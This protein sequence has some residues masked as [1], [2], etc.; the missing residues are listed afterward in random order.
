MLL[1]SLR[2]GFRRLLQKDS[3]ERDLS[4][5]VTHY[6]EM[7]TAEH[8]RRGLSR[9]D[10]ERAARVEFGGVEA[11]KERV[12]HHGWDAAVETVW[13]DVRYGWR[14][15]RRNPLFTLTTAITLAL[16]IGANT[17]M[18]SV[19]NGVM[20]RP[21]PYHDSSRLL[22]L[23]TD[24]IKRSL[25]YEN[26]AYATI[27]DWQRET[28]AFDD[29]AFFSTNR[30]T[31]GTGDSRERTLGAYASANLFPLLGI[32]PIKGRWLSDDDGRGQTP[33]AVISY[34]LWQRRFAADPDII[35]KPLV[36]DAS[37]GKAGP[38]SLTI[39]G[40]MPPGFY[41]PNR[42]TDIWVPATAYWR[43]TRESVERFPSWARRWTG[44]GRVKTGVSVA[45]ARAD[46]ARVG[47]HLAAVHPTSD[48]DFPGFA[49]NAVPILEY[50]TG[51]RL[52]LAL[53]LLMGAVALVL[54]VACANVGNLLLARGASR[55]HEVAVRRALGA[56][57]L[58]LVRQFLVESVLLAL[59]G[60]A[61]GVLVAAGATRALAVS[62]ADRLPRVNEISI[63]VNVLLFAA[64][65]SL[66]SGVLF[67]VIP[68]MRVTSTDAS[69]WLKDAAALG[70]GP[71]MRR[72]RG[73]LVVAECSLAVVLLVGAG[74]LLRSLARVHAVDQGFDTTNVLLVRIEF[75]GDMASARAGTESEP[76]RAHARE[77]MLQDLVARVADAPAVESTGLVDDM[78]VAR[79]GNKSITFPGR[80]ASSIPAGELHETVVTPGF[81]S[82]MRVPIV[83]GRNLVREDAFT[84]I[85]ALWTPTVSGIPLEEKA[86]RAIPE[87]VVVNEAFVRRFLP[88]QNPI[89]ERF[90]VDPT[91]KTYC[92][93]IVGVAGD[94]HRSGPERAA[95]PQ[96]FGPY[97]PVPSGRADLV[98]RT[99]GN[100]LAVAG[101]VREIVNRTV[102]G[103]LMP[104][105]TTADAALGQLTAQ[106]GLQT[107]LLSLFAGLA[108]ALAAVGIYGIVHYSVSQRT[109]EIGVRVALG[110][111]P[112]DVLTLVII[113][114]M[115]LPLLGVALGL[116][117][118]IGVTRVMSH[119][120]FE[121]GT[122]DPMT[123]AAVAATLCTFALAACY[124]PARRAARLDAVTALRL[125]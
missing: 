41:F 20:L 101:T 9:A 102:P 76:L 92:Y 36:L 7:A 47:R 65:V 40:V 2:M 70:G 62:A 25:H 34:A 69:G 54:L 45:D 59:V 106:R 50:V 23:W 112:R 8:V 64:I 100:P 121:V 4:D 26:T 109:R 98:V 103:T 87:P 28:T 58:R 30:T 77:Q 120:L 82:T 17:A 79:Q 63:D 99:R 52:Q 14:G 12:R 48:A 80:D 10:A 114:G 75:P 73:L 111:R 53:W 108:L 72:T 11:V 107:W 43:E 38:A 56:S 97:F 1:R 115:R 19:V 51:A 104:S 6:L 83:R 119:L 3:V 85:R 49:V 31:L 116:A 55:L 22:L 89:G 33:V 16:G 94:M 88:G 117:A 60:G 96:Y 35:G 84:K 5:E 118:A 68:S 105:I 42:Q 81:F 110:A 32:A 46:L 24:D 18:F 37:Q 15:L 86:R 91:N 125:E 27:V 95:I 44:I 61:L 124:G 113:G 57:R 71:R 39:V 122:T 21:L 13:Q 90:C 67:G 66:I 78:F 29:I 123:F 74:L 93:E